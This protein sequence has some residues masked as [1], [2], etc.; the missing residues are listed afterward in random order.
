MAVAAA[1]VTCPSSAPMKSE[2]LNKP[3]RKSAPQA[4]SGPYDLSNQQQ[5][6]RKAGDAPVERL[7][8][9]YMAAT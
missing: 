3:P 8:D 1:A 6:R 4:D 5:Q 7:D 9:P 2:A